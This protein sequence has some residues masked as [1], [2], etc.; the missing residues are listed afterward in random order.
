[1]SLSTTVIGL[2][3]CG[4]GVVRRF[5]D[6]HPKT[7]KIKLIIANTDA[8]ALK[9]DGCKGIRSIQLG[10]G[11]GAGMDVTV[12]RSALQAKQE[13]IL[14]AIGKP[15]CIIICSGQGGGTG[16]GS[17]SVLLEILREQETEAF[18]LSITT[19][20][21]LKEGSHQVENAR[22][23]L[24]DVIRM[25]D[26]CVVQSNEHLV[27]V[28]RERLDK[29]KLGMEEAMKLTN[30]KLPDVI[31]IQRRMTT[32]G[33]DWNVD[34]SDYKTL[35]TGAGLA[36][37]GHGEGDTLEE[38]LGEAELD[39]FLDTDFHDA[40]GALLIVTGKTTLD[41]CYDMLQL[42]AD[43]YGIKNK[44]PGFRFEE[45][46]KIKVDLIVGGVHSKFIDE[47]TK[48]RDG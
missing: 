38:A 42:Y 19:I 24:P 22:K 30:S 43:K 32:L 27:Q 36:H 5:K 20:P 14:K 39:R 45:E 17:H 3:G 8:V 29:P 46:G 33:G 34:W 26:L 18:L 41:E 11:E 31:D 23:G 13:T 12:G 47:F 2:G 10:T 35:V 37:V 4:S 25:S 28:M 15:R 21:F 9:N 6:L 16:T 44:R 7:E 48:E 1:M 40:K